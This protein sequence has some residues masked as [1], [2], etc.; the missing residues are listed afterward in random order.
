MFSE[1]NKLDAAFNCLF[2]LEATSKSFRVISETEII[3]NY[4]FLDWDYLEFPKRHV[5]ELG[6]QFEQR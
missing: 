6:L 3:Y 2:F 1:I 5:F 4:F